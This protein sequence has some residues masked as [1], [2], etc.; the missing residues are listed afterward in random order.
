MTGLWCNWALYKPNQRAVK[1]NDT[2]LMELMTLFLLLQAVTTAVNSV[3]IFK[4]NNIS[5]G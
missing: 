4:K 3:A 2:N 1:Q 5:M